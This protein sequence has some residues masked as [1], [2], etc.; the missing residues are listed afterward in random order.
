MCLGHQPHPAACVHPIGRKGRVNLTRLQDWTLTA[1]KETR[2]LVDKTGCVQLCGISTKR[3]C[4]AQTLIIDSHAS[5]KQWVLR[6]GTASERVPRTLHGLGMR[7]PPARLHSNLFYQARRARVIIARAGGSIRTNP[8]L[9]QPCLS[10]LP[11]IRRHQFPQYQS[12]KHELPGPRNL[13]IRCT[14]LLMRLRFARYLGVTIEHIAIRYTTLR[15]AELEY[16]MCHLPKA[17]HT[18]GA[19]VITE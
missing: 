14:L 4:P 6:R 13:S 16:R 11:R 7:T 10:K 17:F 12:R 8:Q 18:Q 2:R 9:S 3:Q 19:P 5:S 1:R 15:A